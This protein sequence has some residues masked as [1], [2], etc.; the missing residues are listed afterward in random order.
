MVENYMQKQLWAYKQRKEKTDAEYANQQ[1][2]KRE[3]DTMNL[4]KSWLEATDEQTKQRYNTASRANLLAEM[5]SNKAREK[6]IEMQWNAKDIVSSYLQGFPDDYQ[7]LVNFT[8]SNQDPEEFAIEMWWMERP[9]VKSNFFTNVTW[10]AYDS[11]TWI[12]R[13]IGKWAAN[14]IWWVAKQFWADE[15]KVNELVQSYKDYLDSD[16]SAKAIGADT[17][18]GAYKTSKVVSD[19]AQ[20]AALWKL[21]GMALESK[22]WMPLATADDAL[23]FKAMAWATEWAADMW[24]YSMVSDS[25]L[26]SGKDLALWAWL[27]AAVPIAWAVGKAVSKAIKTKSVWLAEDLLQNV[28]RMT[29]SEQSKFASRF[30]EK[31][32][33]WLND[34]WLQSWDDIIE[35]FTRSKDKVDNALAAIEWRFTSKELN[36][37]LDD[38][39]DFA[40]E[41]KNPNSSRMIE[42]LNK[43][44]EWGL[45]MSEINE[46]K[47]FFEAHNKFNYLTKWTAKQSE[48]AT[49]MDSALREW[50]YKI[51]EQNW[52]TNLAELNKETAA[53]KEILNGVKKWEAWVVGNNP[54]SL[55]DIIVAAGWWVSP[56]HMAMAFLKKWLETPTAKRK[57]VDMLNWIGGHETM[58]EKVADLERIAQVN[59]EKEL[60]RLY[61][62]WWVWDVTPKLPQSYWVDDWGK[63]ILVGN[64]TF[65]W[66][67]EW[68]TVVKEKVTELPSNP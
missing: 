23:V 48:L 8:H 3:S 24:I 34:R 44:A 26:P 32:G 30:G 19:L 67:P 41:T 4:Y 49:N 5:I 53:A 14:A 59:T 63:N 52:F 25:E 6:W 33:K 68:K 43:N 29:K 56:E 40:I 65:I 2:A 20:T 9:E 17:D 13:M 51:A 54:I 16:W 37:V 7:K 11:A 64:D 58:A 60:D 21:W 62:E 35:Y 12:P 55:T 10:G 57:I 18:S 61:K 36:D 42:L 22:L 31:A 66:T 38:V 50:Q 47:R 46:V 45:T 15:N 28:N 27:W 39:V 1:S